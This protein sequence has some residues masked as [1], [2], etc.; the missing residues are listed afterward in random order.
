MFNC[1][2]N[3]TFKAFLPFYLEIR[4]GGDLA[5]ESLGTGAQGGKRARGRARFF[6]AF[7]PF[8]LYFFS[9]FAFYFKV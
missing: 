8:S 7:C 4:T 5:M 3:L 1:R 6:L 9:L 2:N